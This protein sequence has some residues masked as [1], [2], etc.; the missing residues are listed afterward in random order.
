MQPAA[1]SFGGFARRA[2]SRPLRAARALDRAVTW[3]IG[4]V[5]ALACALAGYALWDAYAT[6]SSG[7]LQARLAALKSGDTVSFAELRAINPDV[8]AWVVINNT[9]IDY[10][11][12]RGKD[13]FEYLSKDAA[14]DYSAAGSIFLDSA[15]A[16]DFSEPYE[17]LM[18]H[19]MQYGKMLGDLDKFLDASFF[20]QN[21]TGALYLPDR[22]LDLQICAVLQ[23]NAYD[24]I[25]YG[26]PVDA[27]RMQALVNKVSSA[28]L[29]QRDGLPTA[30]DQVIALSTCAS[31][32]VNERTVL[33]C[34]VVGE[35]EANNG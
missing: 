25:L 29:Y 21:E 16:A 28:A 1:D 11:V 14:G 33:V 17:V 13:N 3:A 4:I 23:V 2:P 27:S 7:S 12:V 35:R 10:P 22:T 8:C 19:H 31:S 9:G 26:T 6:V 15:C 32:G 5:L 20:A 34:R 30:S 18:G 24:G